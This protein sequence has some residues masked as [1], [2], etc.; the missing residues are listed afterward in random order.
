MVTISFHKSLSTCLNKF[1]CICSSLSVLY[2]LCGR[3]RFA[4][5]AY[6][7]YSGLFL[8]KHSDVFVCVYAF[9]YICVIAVCKQEAPLQS[10]ASSGSGR[11]RCGIS[12]GVARKSCYGK[13][14]LQ[15][16]MTAGLP[17]SLSYYSR[18]KLKYG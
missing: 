8:L 18:R 7:C 13:L 5:C 9:C 16:S 4:I 3:K 10:F 11:M 1:L 17:L 12:V 6:F 14:M 2:S 15:R